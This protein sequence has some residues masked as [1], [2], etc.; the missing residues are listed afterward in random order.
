VTGTERHERLVQLIQRRDVLCRQRR[1]LRDRVD[2]L[3]ARIARLDAE[4][5]KAD[6]E[7]ETLT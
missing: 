7:S 2:R 3:D 4:I 6:A 1:G 5:R